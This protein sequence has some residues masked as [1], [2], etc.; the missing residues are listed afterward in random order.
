MKSVLVVSVLG[1][2]STMT[3]ANESE[4]Y[5]FIGLGLGDSDMLAKPSGTEFQN[6]ISSELSLG[7]GVSYAINEDWSYDQQFSV[8]HAFAD[9]RFDAPDPVGQI[10]DN[11]T[12]SG[13]W[14]TAIIKRHNLFGN[15]ITPFAS[16]AV[17]VVKVNLN[18]FENG[19]QDWTYG[20]RANLGLE[21]ITKDNASVAI[22][23]GVSDY[24]GHN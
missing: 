5:Y 13:I 10:N 3:F 23:F 6:S 18:N 8:S 21:F 7:T 22:T 20:S 16:L 9:T 24:A 17:G 19:Y 15:N 2:L 11:L 4:P 14:T 12:N 1:L